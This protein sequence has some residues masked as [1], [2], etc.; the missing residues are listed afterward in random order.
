MDGRVR[1]FEHSLA[2]DRTAVVRYLGPPGPVLFRSG[3]AFGLLQLDA[4]LTPVRTLALPDG[5]TE[6]RLRSHTLLQ[7]TGG[8]GTWSLEET[9]LLTH[10]TSQAARRRTPVA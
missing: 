4:T 6:I 8:R 1:P 2:G 7:V 3:D 10:G 5:D 9:N